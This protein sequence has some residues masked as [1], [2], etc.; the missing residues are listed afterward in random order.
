M[1]RNLVPCPKGAWVTQK[2]LI[3]ALKLPYWLPLTGIYSPKLLLL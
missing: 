1:Q 2:W 3:M